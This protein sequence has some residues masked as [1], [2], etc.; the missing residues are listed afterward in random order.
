[1]KLVDSHCHLNFPDLVNNLEN[2]FNRMIENNVVYALCV[3]VDL[4]SFSEIKKICDKFD[5][6]SCSVG[7]HPSDEYENKSDNLVEELVNLS[8]YKKVVAI[9]ETGLDFFKQSISHEQCDKFSKHIQ[10]SNIVEKPLIIHTRSA[11]NET[12][13]LL[14][15]GMSSNHKGGVMHCFTESYDFAKKALDLN[16]YISFS[17]II[18]FKNAIELCDTVKKIPLDKILI[19]TDSPYLAPVPFRG[20][21][22]EPSY[23]YKVAEMISE[24]KDISIEEVAEIT[25]NNF[26]NL[27]RLNKDTLF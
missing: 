2:I 12:L 22:N 25:T 24:L 9:G 11:P 17:G 10:A 3:S 15:E 8:K 1:M 26:C 18:T 21:T 16:F 7:I 23:V 5:N 20:K 14:K 13:S 27:F 4:D 6:V 19:E